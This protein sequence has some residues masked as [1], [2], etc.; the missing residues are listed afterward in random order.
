V[1]SIGLVLEADA[2]SS[3]IFIAAISRGTGTYSASGVTVKIGLAQQ[4][5]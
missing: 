3:S 2:A 4:D 5:Y 1:P